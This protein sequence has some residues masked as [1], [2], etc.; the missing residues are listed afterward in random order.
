MSIY[1][2]PVEI[3]GHEIRSDFRAILDIFIDLENENLTDGEKISCMLDILFIDEVEP[4]Q[5]LIEKS[6]EFLNLGQANNDDKSP[7]YGK[8]IFWEADSRYIFPAVDRVLGKSCRATEY[9]HYWEFMGAMMEIGECTFSNITSM[10]KKKKQGKL[11]K[12]ERILWAENKQM[13]EP[14]DKEAIDE[15][16][17]IKEMLKAGEL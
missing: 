15:I 3:C 1:D 9:M 10:R 16:R 17:R 5:E 13:F 6:F 11:S 8:M 2:L 12:E 14:K 4:T 7:D